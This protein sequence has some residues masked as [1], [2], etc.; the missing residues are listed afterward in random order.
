MELQHKLESIKNE[1]NRELASQ[2]RYSKFLDDRKIEPWDFPNKYGNSSKV[3]KLCLAARPDIRGDQYN[4][5]WE[6]IQTKEQIESLIKSNKAR[7]IAHN[8]LVQLLIDK[9]L[10]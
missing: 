6:I 8:Q 1:V 3:W 7:N 9:N 4:L 10:T 5:F 2:I